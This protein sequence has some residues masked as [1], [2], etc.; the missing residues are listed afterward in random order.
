ME[1]AE[2]SE[3]STHAIWLNGIIT[4]KTIVFWFLAYL[5]M[6]RLYR[7][8]EIGFI[9]KEEYHKCWAVTEVERIVLGVLEM[10]IPE[11]YCATW[12][13]LWNEGDYLSSRLE[14]E[15]LHSGLTV[16]RR[17]II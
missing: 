3:T 15:Q 10:I 6:N 14:E 1:A 5:R 13:K 11:F 8:T 17:R 12:E 2:L 9:D 7:A 16:V 4:L